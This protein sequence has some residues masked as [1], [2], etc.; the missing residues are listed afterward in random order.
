MK[1]SDLSDESGN[2]WLRENGPYHR[3]DSALSDGFAVCRRVNAKGNSNGAGLTKESL[4]G[5]EVAIE[6]SEPAAAAANIER[7]AAARR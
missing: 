6:F 3:T 7:L 4:R 5:A 2:H 1:E